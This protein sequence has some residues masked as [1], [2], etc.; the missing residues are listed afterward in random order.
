MDGKIISALGIAM[1]TIGTVFTL[2]TLLH[3]DPKSVGTWG[4]LKNK[5]KEFPKEQKRARIGYVLIVLGGIM[6]IIG[7]FV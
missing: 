1:A 2:W 5:H 3:T 4:E 6:Q 7:L